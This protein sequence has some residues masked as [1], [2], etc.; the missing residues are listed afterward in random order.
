MNSYT[1]MGGGAYSTDLM[2]LQR[3]Q[4]LADM[5]QQQALEPVQAPQGATAPISFTN[6]LAKAMQG[7]AARKQNQRIDERYKTLQDQD[8]SQ[9]QALLR[10][11][12][13]SATTGT[14][15]IAPQN[16]QI[17]ASLP[18]VSGLPA[19]GAPV[20]Q[21]A[22]LPGTPGTGPGQQAP[23]MQQQ[24][25]AILAARGGP[26][27]QMIQN[28][29][30]PQI[31]QRQNLDYQHQLG[32]DDK[33]WEAAQ[34][35][36][37]ARQQEIDAQSK[38][39]QGNA[40]FANQLAPTQYQQQQLG[41][42]R[43]KLADERKKTELMYGSGGAGGE[44][45]PM[46]PYWLQAVASGNVPGIQSVP[47]RY[48]DRVAKAM[49]T[50][51]QAVFAPIA[52]RRFGMASNSIVGP[53]M[54]LPQYELTANGLPYIQRIQAAL[55]K[56]G[57]VSD[58]ELLDSFTKL[59]TSGNA[60]TDA[61][62]HII[63][64]GKSLSD[65]L[66]TTAQSLST[67][68]I[69]S[70]DQRKQIQEIANATYAKYKEGYDPL[71]KEATEKLQAAGIPKAFWTIPDLNKLNAAQTS[72]APAAAPDPEAMAWLKANPNDP[73]AAAIRAKLGIK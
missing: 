7:Y 4:Q 59:S 8:A 36:P 11:L 54:K 13:P 61:Q 46:V 66:G 1:D 52:A 58:Q 72:G 57:S 32:R 67:G 34:S 25:A 15:S 28:A 26:Q 12:M 55:Q 42:E 21:Q 39:A 70:K 31:M 29:M 20:T 47:K 18:Q 43:G 44:D 17:S 56:P 27:T 19:P 45:D 14:A 71:Y 53:M 35:M 64:G 49:A 16:T 10:Q 5:L 33:T 24:M 68:G 62:V 60:I 9:A 3:Q 63:T 23:D 50:A 65:W 41:L 69:L 40:Q 22:T 48:Q 37:L 2:R 30:L 73:R 38:A 51:P 6:V